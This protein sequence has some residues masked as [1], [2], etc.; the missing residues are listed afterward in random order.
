VA[1]QKLADG[2]WFIGGGSHDSLA[3][4]FKDF[5]VVVRRSRHYTDGDTLNGLMETELS[6]YRLVSGREGRA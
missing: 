1:S 2:V 5:A 6:L 3:V 4:E